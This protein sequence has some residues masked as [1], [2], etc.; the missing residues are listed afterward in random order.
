MS[1]TFKSIFAAAIFTTAFAPAA[2]AEKPVNRHVKVSYA[3]LDL[4]QESGAKALLRRIKKA[5]ITAC[6]GRPSRM[7]E[8]IARFEACR[9]KALS[10]A[11]HDVDAPVLTGLFI[12]NGGE[13]IQVAAR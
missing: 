9:S 4:S 12:R 2:L 10:T 6:G 11:I 7:L 8:E 13:L 5:S 1:R 3:D